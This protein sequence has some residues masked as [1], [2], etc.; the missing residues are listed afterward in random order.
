M[1]VVL[2]P[3]VYVG[4][5]PVRCTVC[6]GRVHPLRLRGRQHLLAIIYNDRGKVCGE[7]CRDCLAAGPEAIRQ[8]LQERLNALQASVQQ[9]QELVAEPIDLPTVEQEFRQYM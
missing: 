3:S 7:L 2:E 1:K 4:N 6:S 5:V 8:Q 9:L